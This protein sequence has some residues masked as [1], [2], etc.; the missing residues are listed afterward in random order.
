VTLLSS[1]CKFRNWALWLLGDVEAVQRK[2]EPFAIDIGETGVRQQLNDEVWRHAE[3]LMI[4]IDMTHPL[5]RIMFAPPPVDEP[6]PA[7]TNHGHYDAASR[8]SD[9]IR[10]LDR[11]V[12][13]RNVVEA[14]QV[15]YR[16]VGSVSK[17]Q[18][19]RVFDYHVATGPRYYVNTD[20]VS[21]TA[22]EIV[23][24]A[25]NIQDLALSVCERHDNAFIVYWN[26]P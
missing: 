6:S 13:I 4:M 17:W 2:H 1:G 14:S 3:Q 12:W 7:W 23:R 18:V 20:A 5:I 19:C 22:N 25:T 26:E 11:F 15:T 9:A 10:F 24:A 16:I 8:S 21:P